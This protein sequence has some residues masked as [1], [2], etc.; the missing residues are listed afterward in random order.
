[1][2]KTEERKKEIQTFT[3]EKLTHDVTALL[4]TASKEMENLIE[5]FNKQNEG[6][7]SVDDVD[8]TSKFEPLY[9]YVEDYS[10]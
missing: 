2:T 10:E 4:N 9:D 8:V 5:K 6:E 3:H 1:M 7:M